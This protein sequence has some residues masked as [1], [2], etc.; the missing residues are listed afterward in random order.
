M[1]RILHIGDLHLGF[2]HRYLG[3]RAAK[4]A[5]EAVRTLERVVEWVLDDAHEVAGVLIAGDLFERHDPEQ[6][7]AARVHTILQKIPGGGRVLVTIPGNHDEFSYPDSVFRKRADSWPGFL[8]TSPTPERVTTIDLGDIEVEIYGMAYTAGISRRRLEPFGAEMSTEV[9]TAATNHASSP[10]QRARIALLHGTLDTDPSDRS[11]RID[12][13]TLIESGI[14]YAALGHIHKPEERPMGDGLAIY[15]G[16][17]IGKGFDDPGVDHLTLISFPHGRPAVERVPFVVRR[18]ENRTLD[19][20]EFGEQAALAK[21]AESGV[22][23]DLILR[24]ELQGEQPP[25]YDRD[26]LLGRLQANCFHVVLDDQSIAINEAELSSIATQPTLRGL[27]VRKI[28]E[29]MASAGG[30]TETLTRLRLALRKGLA[31]F[32]GSGAGRA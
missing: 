1:K 17:L 12:R 9:P 15:P 24:L 5:E 13:Q 21:A 4:R 11:F 2:A 23:P 22:D 32:R 8:A 18:I 19:L 31:A 29:Q 14:S 26:D 30:D 10:T 27:F 25:D 20:S 16:T 7:L 3:D 28:R 6:A